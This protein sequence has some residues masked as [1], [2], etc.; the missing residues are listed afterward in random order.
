MGRLNGSASNPIDLTA[1]QKPAAGECELD[2]LKTISLKSIKFAEDVRPPYVGTYTKIPLNRSLY[3]IGRKPFSRV[4]PDTNYDYDSEAEWEDPGEGEDLTSEGEEEIDE[5]EDDAEME[6]FLDDEDANDVAR[7]VKRKPLLGD[8]IPASSGICWEG[9]GLSSDGKPHPDFS[10][11]T[12]EV[13]LGLSNPPH[14]TKTL[15]LTM[16]DNPC[17][18][19][20]PYSTSYWQPPPPP[21]SLN[22]KAV[23][24]HQT[25]LMEPPRIPLHPVN[26][27]GNTLLVPSSSSPS[28]TDS[29]LKHIKSTS[30]SHPL[31]H[32]HLNNPGT[33]NAGSATT[34][35]PGMTAPKAPK[36][37]IAPEL[38][39]AFKAAVQGSDLTKMGL[40][41]VLKKQFP[42]Q[43]KDAIKDTLE[44]LAVRV[45]EK[46]AD[47]R[48]VLKE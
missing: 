14:S 39:G 45:G 23:G 7:P 37:Y 48:W 34:T 11:F 25:T 22:S 43:P 29:Q 9:D 15:I 8:L 12:M 4:R 41:E 20:D 47:K 44:E 28:S 18:P 40:I 2:L 19:I 30:E 17:F 46:I 31:T 5:E 21:K 38:L 6:G 10:K 27:R 24:P 36:R 42:K 1:Q 32:S 26:H 35:T 13:L 16:P 33:G 3:S